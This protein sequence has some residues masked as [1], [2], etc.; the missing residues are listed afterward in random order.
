MD[1]FFRKCLEKTSLLRLLVY[2]T[3]D[4]IPCERVI[5]F[6]AGLGMVFE[7]RYVDEKSDYKEELEYWT[8]GKSIVPVIVNPLNARIMIGCPI[9]MDEFIQRLT[10]LLECS[11]VD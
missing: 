8:S 2:V 4:C 3:H 10:N 11:S 7:P 5:R 6:L 1:D 9:T